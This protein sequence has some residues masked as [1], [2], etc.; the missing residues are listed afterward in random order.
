MKTFGTILMLASLINYI[1]KL[2][3]EKISILSLST[4]IYLLLIVK[5][6]DKMKYKNTPFGKFPIKE[7]GKIDENQLIND[8]CKKWK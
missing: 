7:N 4:F 8:F 3:K 6:G 1:L 2:K 5:W